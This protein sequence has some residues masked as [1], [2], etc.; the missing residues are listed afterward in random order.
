MDTAGPCGASLL[1]CG[2]DTSQGAGLSAQC[3]AGPGCGAH[4]TT[5]YFFRI[6]VTLSIGMASTVC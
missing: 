2:F 4:R 3:P 5:L 1:A 6:A